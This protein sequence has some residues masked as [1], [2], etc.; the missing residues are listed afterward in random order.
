MIRGWCLVPA[1]VL[2]IACG[3]TA[4]KAVYPK[5]VAGGYTLHREIVLTADQASECPKPPSLERAVRLVYNASNP[6]QL[7]VCETAGSSVAFESIQTWRAQDGRRAAHLGR[8]FV[9]AQA[10]K[11]DPAAVDAFLNDF[12]KQLR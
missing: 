12:E 10:E 11:P 6:I 9:V 3:G 1:F 7:T 8:Y 2:L 5:T 4:S